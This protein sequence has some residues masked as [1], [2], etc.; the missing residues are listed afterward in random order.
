MITQ[1]GKRGQIKEVR[2]V[3]DKTTMVFK[4]ITVDKVEKLKELLSG[5]SVT[6]WNYIKGGVDSYFNYKATNIKIDDLNAL[7]NYLKRKY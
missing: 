4:N 6:E 7:D 1:I 3:E 5:L 2:K